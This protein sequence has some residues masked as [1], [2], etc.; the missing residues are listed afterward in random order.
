MRMNDIESN[1]AENK[2]NGVFDILTP[3]IMV[4]AV[5]KALNCSMTGLAIA[6]PSYINRVYE[7]QTC[8]GERIIAKF[9]RPARWSY[10][11]LLNEHEFMSDC[12]KAEIPIAPPL[13]LQ[14]K[15]TIAQTENIYFSLFEKK[16]GREFDIRNKTDWIR[17]GSILGRLH[18]VGASK[19]APDRIKLHPLHVTNQEVEYLITGGF[20][21][22]PYRSEFQSI[23]SEI[24]DLIAEHF[25][26]IEYI[27]TH[28]DCHR[29]NLLERPGEGLMMIDFDDMMNAPPIQDLWLL[30][31]AHAGECKNE[32]N[33][34]LEGYEQ[35]C[36]F[37]ISTLKLIEPLR[38]MRIIY[39]LSWCASQLGDFQF[40][41]HY[42][43]WGTPSFWMRE[44]ND[45]RT[46]LEIIKQSL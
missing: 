19:K 44:N 34:L 20:I 11:A 21:Q 40:A 46:Q 45:L 1:I 26:G 35:F 27:R 12:H 23:C 29:G 18:I 31:P 9:Y 38:V 17:M 7:F 43:D 30:L 10:N 13:R 41:T 5:E 25:D 42:P 15:S 39:F 22:E 37:D 28:G 2:A 6:M 36:D 16:S 3:E 14:N 8:D 33:L 24:I 32:I 4:D